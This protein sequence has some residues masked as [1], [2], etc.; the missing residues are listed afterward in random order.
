MYPHGIKPTEKQ[1]N[2]AIKWTK[3][4]YKG[5]PQTT[6]G[7]RACCC[8]AGCPNMYYAEYLNIRAQ[9]LD[10]MGHEQRLELLMACIRYYLMGQYEDGPDGRVPVQKPCV[11]LGDDNMCTVYEARPLKCRT[12]GLVPPDMHRRIVGEVSE[13]SGLPKHEIPLCIQCPFVKIKPEFREKFPDGCVP[14]DMIAKIESHLR[15]IDRELGIPAKIQ[16]EGY[17]F[18]TFHDWHLMSVLGDGWMARLSPLREEKD[19]EWKEA[20][21][22]DLKEAFRAAYPSL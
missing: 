2:D 15:G 12:Y 11:H 13:E 10:S 19:K 22:G 18:L 16:E 17:G 6:C 3:R 8:K 7:H 14:E 9:Y 4:A 21:V 20:F 5:L 1:V